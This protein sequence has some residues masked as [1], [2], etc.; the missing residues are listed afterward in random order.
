MKYGVWMLATAA[1][2]QIASAQN[3]EAL[4]KQMCATCHEGGA[5]R[6]PSREALRAMSADRVLAALESG[7]MISV[8]S[9]R[10]VPER[11]AIAEY[12]SGKKLGVIE[13]KPSTQAL[14]PAGPARALASAPVWTGWGQGIA[15]THFQNQPG[16]AASDVPRLK[17]KWA[18][19]FPGDLQSYAK[20][21][22]NGDR[23]Y[24]GSASGLVYSLDAKTGCV[25]WYFQADSWVR[26]AVNLG[27]RTTGAGP[28]LTAYF[29]DGMA[30][31]YAVDA[32]S[33]KLLWKTKVDNYPVARVT[34]SPT[35]YRNVLYVPLASGEEGAGASPDYECCRFR[36]AL[37]AL[38]AQDGSQIWKTYMID[39]PKPTTKNKQGTQLWG[40]SGAPI[41]S[42]PAIDEKRNTV[43]VTTGDNYSDPA[44][45]TSDGFVAMDLATGKMLWSRQ[46]T[47][48]DSYNVA[49]RMPDTTN[50]PKVDGPDLDFSSSP[51]LVDLPGGKRALVAGQKSGVVHA[52]DPDN[53]GEVIWQTRIGAGG[54]MGGVQ[55][56]SAADANNVYVALSD[57]GRVRLT[58]SQNTD[59]DPKKGGGMFALRLAD[60]K[61]VWHTAPG[62]CDHPR[63][64][65]AQSG[66]VSAMPGVA[67]SGSV[68]GHIRAYSI[69]DGKV[70]WDFDTERDYKTVNGVAGRGGSLDGAGPTI[71]A[72]MLYVNS[73]YPTAG[74]T[75]GN[76]LL[77]FSV[78]GK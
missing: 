77:G 15:N 33:G 51:I 63:C 59:A 50:C 5:D 27:M 34:G 64:S 20:V 47:P 9:R 44:T 8:T 37:V 31:M 45:R 35:L 56:G 3:G 60:G 25:H 70:I 72:G 2:L 68:D 57:I 40:P 71:G 29:G 65:P 76:V 7:P 11:R 53:Q 19:A 30:N 69:I 39:E 48:D 1:L 49:C 78:D 61:Q 13:T 26:A 74:G 22:I 55:W 58:Y 21:A 24:L 46:M 36:G 28:M 6:A 42:S 54:S 52:V 62:V 23:L 10:S 32:A 12:V 4:Y 14:C 73:G 18:F 16:F 17:V 66:A 75:P 38:R 43:Y 41:W 67:F